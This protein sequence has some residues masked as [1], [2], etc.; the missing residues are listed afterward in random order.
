MVLDVA[1]VVLDKDSPSFFLS[2]SGLLA[3]SL[4]LG[5]ASVY[6]GDIS[7][8][9][10]AAHGTSR[11]AA[12]YLSRCSGCSSRASVQRLQQH[13]ECTPGHLLN[14][15]CLRYIREAFAE[16]VDST[17]VALHKREGL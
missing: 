9:A 10:G 5:T 6:Y 3:E 14:A 12:F 7:V 4:F 2:R 16:K 1:S 15:P 13:T 11:Y 8:I 17:P